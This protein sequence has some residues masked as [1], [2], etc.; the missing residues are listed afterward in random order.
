MP[1]K[2][3]RPLTGRKRTTAERQ[4]RTGEKN[5]P[6]PR[7]SRIGSQF[8]DASDGVAPPRRVAP[9]RERRRG[10][11]LACTRVCA[12]LDIKHTSGT[13][14]YLG[15]IPDVGKIY[16]REVLFELQSFLCNKENIH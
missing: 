5:K 2:F 4:R 7:P 10:F 13:R 9:D 14:K 1:K 6:T 11:R 12:L 8:A 3:L 15:T 16:Q